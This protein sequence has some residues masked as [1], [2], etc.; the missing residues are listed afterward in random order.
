[1]KNIITTHSDADGI[2]SCVLLSIALKEVEEIRFPDLFGY[3][4]GDEKYMLDSI[5]YKGGFKGIVIDHHPN[6]P[7]PP[8][9]WLVYKPYPTVRIVYEEWKN[10][11]PKEDTWKVMIGLMGDG[12]A[13]LLPVEI[14]KQHPDLL[15]EY[16]YLRDQ[17]GETKTY[18]QPLY[19]LISSPIN[20]LCR[21]LLPKE[22][23]KIILA[24]KHPLDILNND[25]C[26]QARRRVDEEYRK[27]LSNYN[28][29][30]LGR[31]VY[32]Q[33]ETDLRMEGYLASKLEQSTRKT[34]IVFNNKS[35]G[36]SIRGVLS[37]L[38]LEHLKSKK[39]EG[40]GGHSGF[41]GGYIQENKRSLLFNLIKELRI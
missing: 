15:L 16:C 40:V 28:P 41:S 21:C 24:S 26:R 29:I 13:E 38:I 19:S 14:W 6:H 33:Y 37:D 34:S 23:Y 36:L 1:M 5:P 32:L 9:Y 35:G 39:I 17:Y 25:Q 20:A 11:I 30:D 7:S 10:K 22:A 31:I 8:D 3:F 18:T 4:E 2:S 12:Q 27:I